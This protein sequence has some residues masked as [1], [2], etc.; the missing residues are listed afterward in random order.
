MGSLPKSGE[1]KGITSMIIYRTHMIHM[2]LPYDT[3]SSPYDTYKRVYYLMSEFKQHSLFI[4]SLI[5]INEDYT[6]SLIVCI[7]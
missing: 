7:V 5:S 6:H 3:Y 2:S 4:N 1:L